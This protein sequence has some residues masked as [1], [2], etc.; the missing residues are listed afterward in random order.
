MAT[1]K[2]RFGP[3]A[4]VTGAA[5]GLGRA[6]AQELAVRGLDLILVDVQAGK[7]ADVAATLGR[8]VGVTTLPLD[9]S[10]SR[11]AARLDEALADVPLGLVVH[12]AAICPIGHFLAI[13]HDVHQ[14]CVDTNVSGTLAVAHSCARRLVQRQRGGLVLVSSGSALSGAARVANYAATKGYIATLAASL[15][16]ELEAA[17]V[18]VMA[19]CPGMIRTA[20]T[21]AHPPRLD[22]APW[23]RM[24][25]ADR[26]ATESL[27]DLG[28]RLVSVPGG[29]PERLGLT[30]MNR[31][32]PRGLAARLVAETMARLYPS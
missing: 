11:V 13:D 25:S 6:Y 12:C 22:R 26:V 29:L 19:V 9:L 20:A 1:F 23:V 31:V 2:A 7:L 16:P 21:E 28:R 3:T 18:D 8:R 17:G 27:D 10:G 14:R 32:L 5:E 30:L 15:A 24:L 4:L